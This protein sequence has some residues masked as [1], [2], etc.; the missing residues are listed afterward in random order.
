MYKA[1][2]PDPDPDPPHPHFWASRIRIQIPESFYQQ[3]KIV[4]KT[5]IPTVFTTS[6]ELLS[7]KKDV[8]VPSKVISRR[9]FLKLVFCW[10]LEGQ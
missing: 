6:L 3:A 10:H 8:N 7:L 9:T 1:S 5:L 4:R 2:V